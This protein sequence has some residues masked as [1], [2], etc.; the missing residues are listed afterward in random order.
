MA[1]IVIV[2]GEEPN[3]A[4]TYK[5]ALQVY[6]ALK[7]KGYNV[8]LELVPRDLTIFGASLAAEKKGKKFASRLMEKMPK[9]YMKWKKSLEKKYPN[10]IFFTFHNMPAERVKWIIGKTKPWSYP[11]T[12]LELSEPMGRWNVIEIPAVY[13]PMKGKIAERLKKGFSM[14]NIL[15]E[16]RRYIESVTSEKHTRAGKYDVSFE[17]FVPECC[18]IITQQINLLERKS[19]A[20]NIKI[21]VR[22]FAKPI[23]PRGIKPR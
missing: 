17:K 2:R 15:P 14:L 6:N 13:V 12:P 5:K 7:E 21:K 23:K 19:N 9:K 4:V 10:A 8:E 20:G 16:N 18:R 3:E 11:C 22:P 1:K